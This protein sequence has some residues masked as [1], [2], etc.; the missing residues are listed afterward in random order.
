MSYKLQI[1]TDKTWDEI[2]TEKNLARNK[3][4]KDSNEYITICRAN[5]YKFGNEL[6]NNMYVIKDSS[7]N[8]RNIGLFWKYDV[9]H[10]FAL[11]YINEKV[12]ENMNII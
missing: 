6:L 12:F 8:N 3:T 9:A 11:S 4:L 5:V 7:I 2:P 10:M 1:F